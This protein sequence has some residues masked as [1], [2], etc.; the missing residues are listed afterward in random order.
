MKTL[1]IT[2][3]IIGLIVSTNVNAL[4]IDNGSYTTDSNSGL[5]WLDLSET[6]NLTMTEALSSNTGWRFASNI[7]VENLFVSMFDGYYDTAGIGVS[8]SGMNEYADQSIDIEHFESLFGPVQTIIGPNFENLHTYGYYLDESNN[9]RMM[10]TMSMVDN[11]YSFSVIYG[12]QYDLILDENEKGIEFGTYLVRDTVAVAEPTT[13]WLTGVG[14]LSFI[15][16]SK[17]RK[18]I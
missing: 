5:D 3:L 9:Q 14:L 17:R 16:I 8:M 6:A 2:S 18:L 10:G 11:S 13:L 12:Y 15:G 4:F 1:K 7:E